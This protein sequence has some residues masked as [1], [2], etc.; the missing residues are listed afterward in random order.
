MTGGYDGTVVV[1][2]RYLITKHLPVNVLRNVLPVSYTVSQVVQPHVRIVMNLQ[3]PK[4][5]S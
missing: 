1:T 2:E 5:T 3:I 4:Y